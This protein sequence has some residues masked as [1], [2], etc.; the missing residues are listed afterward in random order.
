MRSSQ[1]K[2]TE[3]WG[4]QLRKNPEFGLGVVKSQSKQ[5]RSYRR[6]WRIPQSLAI[7]MSHLQVQEGCLSQERWI[8]CFLEDRRESQG[9]PPALAISRVTLIPNDCYA[10]VACF[11]MALQEH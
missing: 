11:A 8:S 9:I 2:E 6:L 5:V 4:A 10:I 7:R 1:G 3:V